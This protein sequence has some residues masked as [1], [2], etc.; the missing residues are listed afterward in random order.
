MVS[1][2]TGISMSTFLFQDLCEK[3]YNEKG[4]WRN[5]WGYLKFLTL[6]MCLNITLFYCEEL[7]ANK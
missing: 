5:E 2:H 4:T 7:K 6:Y 1:M 3:Q